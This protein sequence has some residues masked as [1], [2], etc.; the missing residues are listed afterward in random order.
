LN[1]CRLVTFS[2][3]RCEGSAKVPRSI[4]L[5]LSAKGKALGRPADT[6]RSD[7]QSEFLPCWSNQLR[8]PKG[9][10]SGSSPFFWPAFDGERGR[11]SDELGGFFGNRFTGKR[12]CF[13]FYVWLLGL[14]PIYRQRAASNQRERLF[15]G[16]ETFWLVSH[17]R[18]KGFFCFMCDFSVY[19]Q[20]PTY[21]RR[22]SSHNMFA[23]FRCEERGSSKGQKE[24]IRLLSL[25]NGLYT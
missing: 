9:D 23:L 15:D 10:S 6:M 13:L 5:C 22:T 14:L 16:W 18:S 2:N 24:A 17:S 11:H 1:F 12:I 20:K 7:N 4:S 19:F 8:D 3:C 21:Q 25:R